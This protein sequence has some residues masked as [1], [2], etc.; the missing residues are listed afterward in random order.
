[1]AGTTQATVAIA[2]PEFAKR[3]ARALIGW[4]PESEGALWIAGRQVQA[5]A[6]PANLAVCRAARPR[7]SDRPEGVDQSG[8]ASAV[9]PELQQHIAQLRAH[10][11]GAQTLLEAGE[12]KLVDL[13]LIIATQPVIHVE[14]AMKRVNGLTAG[15]L[16]AIARITLPIPPATPELPPVAYDPVKQSHF[17][18][19]ANP[20]LRVVGQIGG[21]TVRNQ[22][23]IELPV[24]GFIIAQPQSYL[25]V[26]GLRGR[27]F[28]RD[29][30]HRAFGLLKAGITHAPALV[31]DYPSIEEVRMAPGNLP[32]DAFMGERPPM[33]PD[34]L[35]DLVGVDT[36]APIT[37][38]MIVIQALELT[39]IG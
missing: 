8:F 12:P 14:D 17:V 10:P 2:A 24:F 5:Q 11:W 39:P 19:S 1:M 3:K 15:D 28:L 13:R 36:L 21:L 16:P 32:I 22:N 9:P 31:R 30:Y 34:Y 25:S 6:D 4:L 37:S 27:Y 38:K 20:N 26:A 33:L 7:V 35:D 29:G 23:G 18:S